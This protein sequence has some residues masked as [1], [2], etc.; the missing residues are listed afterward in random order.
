MGEFFHGWRRKVGLL[1]LVMA[2]LFLGGCVR[3]FVAHDSVGFP[4]NKHTSVGLMSARGFLIW[5]IQH[6]ESVEIKWTLSKWTHRPDPLDDDDIR[7]CCNSGGFGIG[8][9]PACL[10]TNG[11]ETTICVVPYVFLVISL[12]LLS[13]YLLQPYLLQTNRLPPDW[14]RRDWFVI[15]LLVATIV[16]AFSVFSGPTVY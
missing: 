9:I 16:V 13:I 5:C 7:W 1:T 3:S 11:V 4:V 6:H 14:D 8:K 2:C 10:K 15:F 12:F